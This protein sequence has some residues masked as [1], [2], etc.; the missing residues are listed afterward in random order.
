MKQRKLGST[1]LSLTAIGFGAW[2]IG[3]PWDFGWGPQDDAESIGTI[4]RGLD[5]GSTGSTPRPPMGWS[6]PRKSS[7]GRSRGVAIA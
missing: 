3:G 4:Q 2:A 7:G 5:A 6:T 1:D